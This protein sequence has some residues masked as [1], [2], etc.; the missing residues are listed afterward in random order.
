MSLRGKGPVRGVAASDL[1]WA[2][3]GVGTNLDPSICALL[4]LTFCDDAL[5]ETT[6][7]FTT[8]RPRS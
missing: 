1:A 6:R 4:I 7:E 3:E 5:K 2:L 8:P